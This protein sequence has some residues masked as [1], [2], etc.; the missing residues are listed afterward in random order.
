MKSSNY[1]SFR[2]SDAKFLS[3][4]QLTIFLIV[5]VFLS[6]SANEGSAKLQK[7][8]NDAKQLTSLQR[9]V[10]QVKKLEVSS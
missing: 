4:T 2:N 3:C 7:V 8:I 10:L 9:Q 5:N 6:D 1:C